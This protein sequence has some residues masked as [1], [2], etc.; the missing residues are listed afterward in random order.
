MFAYRV[1]RAVSLLVMTKTRLNQALT[2]NPDSNSALAVPVR[3]PGRAGTFQRTKFGRGFVGLIRIVSQRAPES[4]H[5]GGAA[6][7]KAI[8][9]N[10]KKIKA[11]ARVEPTTSP[12]I[13]HRQSHATHYSTSS[14]MK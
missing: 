3:D 4:D 13:P 8:K 11:P 9:I 14:D 12:I 7:G 10:V 6:S 2:L 1:L 5:R